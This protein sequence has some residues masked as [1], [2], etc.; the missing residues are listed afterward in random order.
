MN[1]RALGDTGTS[2][3]G[4]RQPATATASRVATDA[5]HAGPPRAAT[6][7]AAGATTASAAAASLTSPSARPLTPT[8]TP[9]P[10]V[11]ALL[12]MLDGATDFGLVELE[13][14]LAALLR[15]PA[16]TPAEQRVAELSALAQLLESELAVSLPHHPTAQRQVSQ[17]DY[18]ATRP[19][20]APT[21]ETLVKRFGTVEKDGWSWACRAASGLLPD[22]RKTKP[23]MGWPAASRGKRRSPRSD[24]DAVIRGIRACAFELLRRPSS[25]VYIEWLNAQRR[26]A[27]DGP[28]GG[29]AG[30]RQGSA[31]MAAV[32]TQ[33]PRG[34]ASA[35]ASADI[36]DAELAAARVRVVAAR[37]SSTAGG[38]A[39]A[40]AAA[41]AT[42]S[43]QTDAL[44][45]TA[46]TRL[47]G[48]DAKDL[49][50]LGLDECTR[51]RLVRTGFGQL[52]LSQA[53][54]LAR[55]LDGSLAWLAGTDDWP[56]DPPDAGA[57]FEP[58]VLRA[59]AK[60]AGVKLEALRMRS[61]LDISGWRAI[62][63]HKREPTLAQVQRWAT[64]LRTSVQSSHVLAARPSHSEGRD[65]EH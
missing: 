3:D 45:P 7:A 30:Q 50:A 42:P 9:T 24:R 47:A 20:G 16:P 19:P 35:L 29:R 13:R 56:G 18:D 59:A 61:K 15:G 11:Q 5:A 28:G 36:T 26:R 53:E 40:T 44:P 4:K 1:E 52:P 33:F 37:S 60:R 48:L 58:D 14:L 65:D 49:A 6:P 55:A 8:P 43:L 12:L 23:G 39:G 2:A 21:A 64:A 32:Y 22:G 57:R 41:R 51:T 34:W 27:N 54:S 31:S 25:N 10:A 46:A 17:V 38:A 62:M 63:T